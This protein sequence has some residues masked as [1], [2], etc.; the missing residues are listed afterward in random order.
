MLGIS[1]DEIETLV[2]RRL[3]RVVRTSYE[4]LQMLEVIS[5]VRKDT[6]G[7]TSRSQHVATAFLEIYANLRDVSAPF[8]SDHRQALN[9][10][11]QAKKGTIKSVRLTVTLRR[12]MAKSSR[13]DHFFKLWDDFAARSKRLK[14]QS[15]QSVLIMP[16][17]R[18]PRY[19]LLLAE[20][21][22]KLPVDDPAKTDLKTA[23]SQISTVCTQINQALRQHEKLEAL[24]GKEDMPEIEGV[25][26]S[27]GKLHMS[28]KAKRKED[29]GGNERGIWG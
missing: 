15:L 21:D 28:Y 27:S 1:E 20:L 17:Q 4:L 11:Q 10:L 24:V 5:L 6:V 16:I 13:V 9:I 2:G 23:L 25:R 12:S 7:R 3:D 26:E 29:G 22:K 19:K 14:G 8:V 18:V